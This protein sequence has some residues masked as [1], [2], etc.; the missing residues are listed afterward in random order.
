VDKAGNEGTDQ[1]KGPIT[2]DPS[3]PR[4]DILDP[5]PAKPER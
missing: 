4:V 2:V 1:W 3:R 5:E